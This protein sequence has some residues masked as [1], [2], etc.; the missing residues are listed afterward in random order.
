[1]IT[2]KIILITG[3]YGHVGGDL[4][5]YLSG[6]NSV[7]IVDND[8][9]GRGDGLLQSN[10]CDL[11]IDLADIKNVGLK[12]D[13]VFHF[14]EYSRVEQSIL[15]PTVVLENNLSSLMELLSF[16][17]ES[18]AK[19]IYSGSSTKFADDGAARYTTPYAFTKYINSE[20][21][22]HYCRWCNVNYAIVYFNNIYGGSEL[23]SGKYATVV[24]KFL[25]LDKHG[26]HLPVNLPGTQRRAF[27]HIDDVLEALDYVAIHGQ[28]DGYI[29][30]PD[31]DYSVLELAQSISK[32]IDLKPSKEGNRI[33]GKLDNSKM[34][35]LGWR[36]RRNIIEYIRKQ[37]ENG[38]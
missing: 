23:A 30:C 26:K 11:K 20:I 15:E 24:A 31:E 12:F 9:M 29:I 33:S 28:G 10:V 27:T 3:G 35:S 18:G 25:E 5:N 34:K 6:E 19:F 8:V 22:D 4:A 14:G 38:L 13:I 21:V 37:K 2:D 16:V 32:N 7:Y 36:P 1:M 17:R